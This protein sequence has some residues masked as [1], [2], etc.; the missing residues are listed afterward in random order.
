[1][2]K[3]KILRYA[4]PFIHCLYFAYGR[5]IYERSQVKSRGN[6]C[7]NPSLEW[8]WPCS[9]LFLWGRNTTE[10]ICLPL[11]MVV[12]IQVNGSQRYAISIKIKVGFCSSLFLSDTSPFTPKPDIEQISLMIIHTCRHIFYCFYIPSMFIVFTLFYFHNFSLVLELNK[13]KFS[14]T[15]YF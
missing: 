4:R 11:R 8:S 6:P 12:L 2:R 13:E 10:I 15:S 1:M 9:F 3:H 5:K 7:G 14:D